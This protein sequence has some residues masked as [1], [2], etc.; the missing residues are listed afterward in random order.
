MM[1]NV[2]C[3]FLAKAARLT[4]NGFLP[5]MIQKPTLQACRHAVS[6]P[7]VIGAMIN[8]MNIGQGL[9]GKPIFNLPLEF[10]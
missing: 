7:L 5:L 3:D 1:H 6:D 2:K 10:R 4:E 9:Q 8:E